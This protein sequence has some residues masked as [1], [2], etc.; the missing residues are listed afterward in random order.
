M[1]PAVSWHHA[2]RTDLGD[3]ARL[4]HCVKR[5]ARRGVSAVSVACRGPGRAAAR[6]TLWGGLAGLF[7]V[8]GAPPLGAQNPVD[9][10]QVVD[11]TLLADTA[12]VPSDSLAADSVFYNLPIVQARVPG[13][14]HTG[15][16]TWDRHSIMASG[17]NTLAELFEEIPGLIPLM[18][19]DYGTPAAM[20]AFGRGS[21]AYRIVRDGFELYPVDG[22]VVDLQHVGLSGVQRI[23]LDRS[24]NQMVV[25][26]WTHRFDDGRPFSVIEAGTGDLDTNVL[27]GV[28]TDPTALGGSIGVGLERLDTRGS[29][30][31][32]E[33]G[34]NRTG[35]WARYQYHFGDRAGL[36]LDARRVGSQTRVEQYAPEVS[37]TDVVLQGSIRLGEG[38]TLQGMTGRSSLAREPTLSEEY[39]RIGGSRRQHGLRLGLER[40]SLWLNG[41]FRSYEAGLPTRQYGASGG[42][43]AAWGGVAARVSR[44]SWLGEGA[45]DTG[46]RLWLTPLSFVTLFGAYE[47]G[48]YGARAGPIEDEVPRP[49][50]IDDGGVAGS[51]IITERES[52]RVGG[53]LSRWGVSIG[54]AALYTYADEVSPLGLELDAGAPSTQGV[55]RNGFEAT[56]VLPMPLDGL[57]LE[58][59]YQWWD[60]A[61]VYQPGQIYRGSFEFHRVFK[62]S[63][64]LEVWG[65]LGVRGHDPMLTFAPTTAEGGAGIVP[66]P[67]YQSWHAH[68]QVRVVT[69]RLWIGM[70]NMTFRRNLRS[71]PGRP[72]PVGRSFF[73]LR[74]DLWN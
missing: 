67:F 60:E 47:T 31:G 10:L 24:M 71:Y 66:V 29:G 42:S 64:N 15:V 62:E 12:G 35:T 72:L 48:D 25:E 22:G 33:E 55:H 74:W 57:T 11:S 43:S 36:S 26:I 44:S 52:L 69:V 61:G 30:Q 54:G 20:S 59:S 21:G 63:G 13:G 65:S 51:A 7:A 6:V 53:M 5:A 8:V 49:P 14:Y 39:T 34:G 9:S 58:G 41:E 45:M 50:L 1:I 18:G 19:G 2:P 23:R 40:G 17:A 16:W 27:R 28:Y 56:A 4:G 68:L 32:R 46:L 37:R 70:D 73:A 3:G 38:V